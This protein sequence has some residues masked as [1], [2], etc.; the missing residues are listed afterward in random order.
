[1][2]NLRTTLAM[3]T[4]VGGVGLQRSWKFRSVRT[5]GAR[6]WAALTASNSV[7]NHAQCFSLGHLNSLPLEIVFHKILRLDETT[8]GFELYHNLS[9]EAMFFIKTS[10]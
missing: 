7:S 6:P 9:M 10:I 2:D 4:D 8:C 3:V 5:T 1:M